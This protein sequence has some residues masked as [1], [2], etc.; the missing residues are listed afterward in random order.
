MADWKN[1]YVTWP[2][3][4]HDTDIRQVLEWHGQDVPVA[5]IV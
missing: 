5:R 2:E 3:G 1:T 4:R